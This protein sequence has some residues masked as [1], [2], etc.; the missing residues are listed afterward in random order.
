MSLINLESIK[1]VY[2]TVHHILDTNTLTCGICMES[3]TCKKCYNKFN[4]SINNKKYKN[5][6][7]EICDNCNTYIVYK[8]S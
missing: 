5:P 7:Y 3:W 8:A 2:H 4:K 6:I 1:P